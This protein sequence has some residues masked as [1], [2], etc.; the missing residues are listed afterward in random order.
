[1]IYW[2]DYQ[3]EGDLLGYTLLTVGEASSCIPCQTG[4]IDGDGLVNATDIDLLAAAIQSGSCPT[5]CDTDGDGDVD[6]DDLTFLIENLAHTAQSVYDEDT[7]TWLSLGTAPGDANLDGVVDLM[8]IG[9]VGDGYGLGTGWAT[10]DSNG[11]GVVDL[12]DLAA[13]GDS[14]G[15][16]VSAPIPE[17]ATIFLMGCGAMGLLKRRA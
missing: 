7:R 1:M 13:M 9:T 10:G 16:D 2:L 3:T 11:D 14:Y 5:E 4:D 6:S 8:D 17:P 12:I 15:F